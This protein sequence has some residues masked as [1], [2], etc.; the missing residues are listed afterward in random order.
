MENNIRSKTTIKAIAMGCC[1]REAI[2]T[3]AITM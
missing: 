2:N 3:M 1:R